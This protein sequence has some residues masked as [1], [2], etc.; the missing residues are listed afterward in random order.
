MTTSVK[1]VVAHLQNIGNDLINPNNYDDNNY[2]EVDQYKSISHGNEFNKYQTSLKNKATYITEGFNGHDPL[3]QT[4][5]SVLLN[6][7]IS[8]VQQQ[9]LTQLKQDFVLN[10]TKY[11]S[12]IN[13]ILPA[14]DNSAKLQQLAELEKT[15]DLLS[16]QINTLNDLLKKNITSVNNQISTNSSAREKYMKDIT[17]HNKTEANMLNISNNIQNMLND[18]DITTLQKNYSYILLSILAAASIL[19][20]MNV[21]KNN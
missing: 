14:T 1:N 13:T 4:S 11:N 6:T 8:N 5:Q 15:L 9:K 16:Q 3:T 18:S 2:D 19:V 17:N 20:A 7:Q 21:I 10:Q 12:L